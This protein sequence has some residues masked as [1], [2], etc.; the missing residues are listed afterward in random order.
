[1]TSPPG[2]PVRLEPQEMA[3]A[4]W[5]ASASRAFH[6]THGTA[7]RYGQDGD[8]W[9]RA[10]LGVAGEIAYAKHKGVYWMPPFRPQRAGEGD[11]GSVQVRTS[12]RIDGDLILHPR[13]G[14]DDTWVL[15]V[16][17]PPDLYIVGWCWGR[18]GK[19]DRYWGD[20]ARNGRPAFFVPQSVLIPFQDSSPAGINADGFTGV[21]GEVELPVGSQSMTTPAGDELMDEMAEYAAE[22][23]ADLYDPDDPTRP[24][25]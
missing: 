22:F 18:Q 15:V 20:K 6:L 13:D 14:D 16:G 24:F 1:M 10:F 12:S 2:I 3:C 25:E 21:G 7:E 4:Y 9:Q 23:M 17:N 11:V 8:G 5:Y 19:L